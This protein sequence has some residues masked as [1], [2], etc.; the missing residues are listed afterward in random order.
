MKFLDFWCFGVLRYEIEAQGCSGAGADV[1]DAC[2]C[3]CNPTAT[4]LCNA[5]CAGTNSPPHMSPSSVSPAHLPYAHRPTQA[6]TSC[7]PPELQST[8]NI[9]PDGIKTKKPART[10][11][12]E[13][14]IDCDWISHEEWPGSLLVSALPKL[15]ASSAR[16]CTMMHIRYR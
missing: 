9:T 6:Y 8:N 16:V 5:A 1:A 14:T 13:R 3:N 12:K 2:N 4:A 11:G 15:R 10:T 7:Q